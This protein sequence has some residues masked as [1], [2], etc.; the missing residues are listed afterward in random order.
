[1]GLNDRFRT[2]PVEGPSGILLPG[3]LMETLYVVAPLSE[4]ARAVGGVRVLVRHS[5]KCW[6][7]RRASAP[8][9]RSP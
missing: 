2:D 3:V 4:S 7:A 1:M 9:Q 5:S 6:G 8:S